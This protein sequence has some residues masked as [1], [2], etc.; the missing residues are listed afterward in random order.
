M[1]WDAP[2]PADG[3]GN[4]GLHVGQHRSRVAASRGH[5]SFEVLVLSEDDHSKSGSEPHLV[6]FHSARHADHHLAQVS[7]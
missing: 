4:I 6:A 1:V 5:S 7:A 3:A 2:E